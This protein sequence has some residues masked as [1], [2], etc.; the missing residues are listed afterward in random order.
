VV[1]INSA[2]PDPGGGPLQ[3]NEHNNLTG[4]LFEGVMNLLAIAISEHA[5]P[6]LTQALKNRTN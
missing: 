5:P 4:I 6:Q 1:T 3:W 2:S